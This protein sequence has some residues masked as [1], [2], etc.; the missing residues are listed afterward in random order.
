[1]YRFLVTTTLA[2]LLLASPSRGDLTVA[3]SVEWMV[4]KSD[5]V[6][7]GHIVRLE[8]FT[9]PRGDQFTRVTI[10]ID[11]P[12]KGGQPD[13]DTEFVVSNMDLK[14]VNW[15]IGDRL[16]AMLHQRYSPDGRPFTCLTPTNDR[17][18]F[19]VIP[20]RK[21]LPDLYDSDNE[22]IETLATLLQICRQW[23][24]AP[25]KENLTTIMYPPRPPDAD[26]FWSPVNPVCIRIPV[27][28]TTPTTAGA[29]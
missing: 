27:K 29:N 21:T 20:I 9:T 15:E 19:S 4:C 25:A 10:S 1:M 7:L 26:G 8:A 23:S 12:I 18:P 28:P 22:K 2:A 13:T 11:S 5:F 24:S 3:D 16:V 14:N 6:A 17:G